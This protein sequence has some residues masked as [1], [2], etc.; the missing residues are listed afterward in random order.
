V[1]RISLVHG[2]TQT[3]RSWEPIAAKLA[4]AGH[5]VRCPDLP[6]HGQASQVQADLLGGTDLLAE[7]CGV[8]TYVGYSMGGRH[9]LH[10]AL[11][12]PDLVERLVLLGATPGIDDPAQR[13]ARRAADEALASTLDSPP[14]EP[15]SPEERR[16]LD[17]FLRSWLARPLFAT[18]PPGRAGLGDR[19]R[20]TVAGLAASL[21]LAGT[22]A[23]EPL[24][25]RLPGLSVPTLVM[26]GS[27]DTKF[28]ALAHRM[29]VAIG[30]HARVEV[31]PGAGHA[32]HL[33]QPEAFADAVLRFVDERAVGGQR[34][35]DRQ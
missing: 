24:W 13:E 18:L 30:P 1:P 32:A 26:A 17:A 27:L 23:Q 28:C 12:R 4:A 5:E 31:L 16:R 14:V 9:C 29:A 22:G 10:L 11:A 2:F 35:F 21:R 33:E 19:R 20:N 15:G 6:G 8:S 25:E 34:H 3:G 7:A